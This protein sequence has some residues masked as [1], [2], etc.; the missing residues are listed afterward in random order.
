MGQRG[1]EY[2]KSEWEG[3]AGRGAGGSR[4]LVVFACLSLLAVDNA[5]LSRRSG[6]GVSCSECH[7]LPQTR[8]EGSVM[9]DGKTR[10]AERRR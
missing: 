3:G 7:I 2:G 1:E 9:T 8:R 4:V 5:S 10:D 6:R